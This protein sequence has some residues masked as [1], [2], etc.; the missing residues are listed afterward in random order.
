MCGT[1]ETSAG[2]TCHGCVH[3][4]DVCE[5]GDLCKVCGKLWGV[6]HLLAE[7]A[8]AAWGLEEGTDIEIA[9][10]DLLGSGCGEGGGGCGCVGVGEGAE[11]V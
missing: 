4:T 11:R 5:Q 6:L 8:G 2:R 3:T 10:G 1:K 7:G 9:E